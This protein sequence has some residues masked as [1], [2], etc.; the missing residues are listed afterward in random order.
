MNDL[1]HPILKILHILLHP[2]RDMYV[3]SK[4]IPQV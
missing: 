3:I 2:Y 1:D 4:L